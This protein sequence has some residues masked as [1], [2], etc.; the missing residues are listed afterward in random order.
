M[1]ASD[2]L[3][4]VLSQVEA[5]SARCARGCLP[6]LVAVSK[7]KPVAAIEDVYAAGQ[8]HFGENYVNELIA[9]AADPSLPKDIRWHFIGQLQS[10]KAKLLV[11]SVKGLWAVESVD[12]IKLATLLQKAADAEGR[13]KEPGKEAL[14]VFVQ[15]NTSAEPQKGGTEPGE[16]TVKLALHI[17]QSCPSLRL[18]GLMTIG[19]LGEVA[20]VFFDRLVEQREQ[21]EAALQKAGV[22]A[23]AYGPPEGEL[24]HN[25]NANGSSNETIYQPAPSPSSSRL[26]LSMGMSGDFE[27]AIE[28]GSTNVRVGSSIFGARDY[29][30]S[31]AAAEASEKAAKA[32]E[33]AGG[34]SEDDGNATAGA[35][36]ASS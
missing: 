6:R 18:V 1:S 9:K 23:G 2:C 34:E 31:K 32:A 25:A 20:K 30:G 7:T 17:A 14:R 8:R 5:V 36:T 29:K 33:E 13:G 28:S 16:E 24:V 15:V 27:L 10:N 19:K 12:S 3:K 26:E 11:S 4:K 22:K 35:G 21:V